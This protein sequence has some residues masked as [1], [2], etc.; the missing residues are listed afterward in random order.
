[1]K[2][3]ELIGASVNVKFEELACGHGHG[4]RHICFLKVS[5]GGPH[6]IPDG[7][8]DRLWVSIMISD[9]NEWLSLA[10]DICQ[11]LKEQ[12]YLIHSIGPLISK[13][14]ATFCQT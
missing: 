14:P 5:T 10:T 7:Q 4:N 2:G 8:A 6:P 9:T 3:N 11:N 12:V 13:A 1:M